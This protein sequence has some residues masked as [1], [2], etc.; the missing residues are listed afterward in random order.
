MSHEDFQAVA[1][2]KIFTLKKTRKRL[3]TLYVQYGCERRE[4]VH[5]RGPVTGGDPDKGTTPAH[6]PILPL[7]GSIV[8]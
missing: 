8:K 5:R 6:L 1:L 2:H 3:C 4:W 7:S